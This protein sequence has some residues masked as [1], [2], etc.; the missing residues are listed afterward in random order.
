MARQAELEAELKDVQ[1]Q[2]TTAHGQMA[3]GALREGQL[4]ASLATAE[5]Q[6]ACLRQEHE[7]YRHKATT[8]LQVGVPFGGWVPFGRCGWG[9]VH[10]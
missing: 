1:A 9:C 6:L 5:D 7:D 10:W 8:I 2:L 4:V 3:E